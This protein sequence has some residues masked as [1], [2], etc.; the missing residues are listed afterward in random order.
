MVV[1]GLPVAQQLSGTQSEL[2]MIR[3]DPRDSNTI[4]VAA[5]GPLWSGGGDR[6]LFK[7]TDGGETWRK[8]LG[9]GLG[10]KEEDD[11]YTGV[12]EV[13]M[14]PRN[15]DVMYAASYQRRRHTWVLLNGGPEGAIY[16]SI[17]GGD[18]WNKLERGLPTGDVGRID[19]GIAAARDE[20]REFIRDD[21][22]EVRHAA[23]TA[24][25]SLRDPAAL[26]AL[27]LR[28]RSIS[29][30]L[31][32]TRSSATVARQLYFSSNSPETV[33]SSSAISPLTTT[34]RMP[35]GACFG[36]S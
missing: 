15:P 19:L 6:G 9:D 35:S 23:A 32:G 31:E 30:D 3:I 14:D 22:S 17:D 12:S 20:L 2:G 36:S 25:V 8:V 5:Q 33:P 1:A 18:T 21:A 4:F 34:S 10:N 27:I 13:H 11:Q 7:S 16:K 28:G 26:D 24:L 29:A